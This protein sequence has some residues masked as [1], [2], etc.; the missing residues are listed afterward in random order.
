MGMRREHKDG[1]GLA[2]KI[3]VR[4]VAP[5]PGQETR[6]LLAR[7]R[8]SDTETHAALFRI[9]ARSLQQRAQAVDAAAVRQYQIQGLWGS[10]SG[11]VG[12]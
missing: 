4:H 3:D 5:A 1:V 6:I 7:D 2:N 10:N 12:E 9:C 11:I 8:L